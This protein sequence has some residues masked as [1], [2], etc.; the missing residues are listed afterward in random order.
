MQPGDR[1]KANHTDQKQNASD[2]SLDGMAGGV[3][4]VVCVTKSSLDLPYTFRYA[5]VG[6]C[7]AAALGKVD[8]RPEQPHLLP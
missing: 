3:C 8:K 1:R 6:G 5:A 2:L 4:P 7:G